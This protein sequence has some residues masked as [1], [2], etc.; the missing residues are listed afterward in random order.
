MLTIVNEGS[1]LTIVNEGSSLTI[2]NEGSSL[3]IVNE[4]SS[5]TI[6]NEGLSLTIVN[7]TTNFIKTVVFGKKITCNFIECRLYCVD[8]KADHRTFK[9]V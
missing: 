8:I 4:R 1:S 9:L 3:T 5:L 7:E 2:V 6:V